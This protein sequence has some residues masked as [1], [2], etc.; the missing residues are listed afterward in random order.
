MSIVK[1]SSRLREELHKRLKELY[2]S[3]KGLLFKNI[4]VVK[5]A[6][7]RGFKIDA[8]TLSRYIS[9]N[10]KNSSLS[11]EQLIWLCIRYGITIRLVFGEPNI[12]ANGVEL[13]IPPYNENKSLEKLR[14]IFKK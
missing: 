2:P 5:D 8:G 7:E 3:H 11:E 13:V 1:E 9:G 10:T 12:T 14:Q 4:D 6:A